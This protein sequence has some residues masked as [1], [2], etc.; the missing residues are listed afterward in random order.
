V[1][2]FPARDLRGL[3]TIFTFSKKKELEKYCR[4]VTIYGSDFANFILACNGSPELPFYHRIHCTDIVPEHLVLTDESLVPLQSNGV[5]LLSP[6]SK[7]VVN[8][9]GSMFE[10]RRYLVGHMFYTA[11]LH[12]WHFVYF[13]QRDTEDRRPNHW[14]EGAH[15]HLVNWLWPNLDPRTVWNEFVQ[16][17]K[18][19]GGA[20]HIRYDDTPPNLED[21][22][23]DPSERNDAP[24]RSQE[25]EP[26]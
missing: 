15:I 13:D 7:K 19:P 11:N 12:E 6:A 9:I 8:K 22:D 20:V 18:P 23:A 26:S 21:A 5:G 4:D 3:L 24:R 14:K 16:N 17:H 2:I 10:Q 25:N 1:P